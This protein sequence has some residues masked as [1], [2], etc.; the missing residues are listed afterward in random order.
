[1]GDRV[2]RRCK[3]RMSY[4]G[5]APG[6]TILGT[7][8]TDTVFLHGALRHLSSPTQEGGPALR[9]LSSSSFFQK[10]LVSRG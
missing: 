4:T 7:A 9:F 10:I 6:G 2:L 3:K 1:M 5:A 8:A